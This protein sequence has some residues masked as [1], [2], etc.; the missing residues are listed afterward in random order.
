M[1]GPQRMSVGG[2]LCSL[3]QKHRIAW[4]SA[5]HELRGRYKGTYLG[6]LWA[7]LLPLLQVAVYV[8][9]IAVVFQVRS[10]RYSGTFD[11]ALYVLGGMI[12][13]LVI[14][15]VL[16]D[17]PMLVR[18]RMDLVKQV[19]FPIETLPLA[20][21]FVHSATFIVGFGFYL[22][23]AVASAT[24]KWTFILLPLPILLLAFLLIGLSWFLMIAG[25]IFKDLSHIVTVIFTFLIFFTPVLLSV[26]MVG[27]DIWLF[28]MFNPVSHVILCFRDVL[29]GTFHPWSWLVF[30][31]MTF[32]FLL[33]GGWVLG[34]TK[35]LI[36]EYL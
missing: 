22:I 33:A 20:S 32:L 23:L 25:V 14:V 31:G 24:I 30:A 2:L 12:P 13:W 3:V 15:G 26:D 36:N 19:V 16:Q 7:G 5:K 17:A 28:L 18:V 29:L 35:L 34:R 6:L 10:A 21:F 11:Y 4:Q 8:F 1:T 9:V 27:Q